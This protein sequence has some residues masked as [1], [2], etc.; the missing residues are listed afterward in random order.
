MDIAAIPASRIVLFGH[1]LGAAVAILLSH[2]ASELHPPVTFAGIALVAAFSDM[3]TLTKTYRL[4]G[5]MPVFAS[6]VRIL[7][8]VI[9]LNDHFAGMWSSAER[10]ESFVRWCE[11]RGTEYNIVL[12]HARDDRNIPSSH[13]DTLAWRAINATRILGITPGDLAREKEMRRVDAG[14]GGW[15]IEWRTKSGT[16]REERLRFGG[17]NQVK[18]YPIMGL[19]VVRIFEES[20]QKVE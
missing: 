8:T 10:I 2:A 17:H 3:R 13:A 15:N 7:Q 11:A 14:P 9:F 19:A 5:V 6:V 12:V 18:V 1:S 4:E 16:I 20:D